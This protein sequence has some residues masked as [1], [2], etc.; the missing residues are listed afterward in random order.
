M[1]IKNIIEITKEEENLLLQGA[2]LWTD[3]FEKLHI[4]FAEYGELLDSFSLS[5]CLD[6][7]EL[8]SGGGEA[9]YRF[10]VSEY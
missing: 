8:F 4:D 5:K 9:S 1:E 2:K 3:I 10:K 6:G 7:Q